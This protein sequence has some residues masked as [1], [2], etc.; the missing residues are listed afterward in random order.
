MG[1]KGGAK[2]E[3]GKASI[4]SGYRRFIE[5]LTPEEKAVRHE[6]IMA[7]QRAW[8]ARVKA[9]LAQTEIPKG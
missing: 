8:R 2:T 1:K 5:S 6:K 9:A 3:E 4:R 7:G